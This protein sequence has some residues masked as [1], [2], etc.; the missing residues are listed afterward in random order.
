MSVAELKNELRRL[1]GDLS[2]HAND[3]DTNNVRAVLKYGAA[4]LQKLAADLDKA[5]AGPVG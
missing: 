4:E 3:G 1:A 2:E 5:Q